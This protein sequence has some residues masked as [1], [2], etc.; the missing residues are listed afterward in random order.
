[1]L[2]G[3]RALFEVPLEVGRAGRDA[4]D[5]LV[6]RSPEPAFGD[7]WSCVLGDARYATGRH[8]L[9]ADR[10]GSMTIAAG[11]MGRVI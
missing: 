8:A 1:M 9:R 10:G 6:H 4:S 3:P 5:A 11:I 7:A 2:A